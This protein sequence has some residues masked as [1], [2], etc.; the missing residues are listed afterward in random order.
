MDKRIFLY[1]GVSILSIAFCVIWTWLVTLRNRRKVAE[2]QARI[3][4][5]EQAMRDSL[6]FTTKDEFIHNLR[7]RVLHSR[8]ITPMVVLSQ[9]QF[10]TIDREELLLRIAEFDVDTIKNAVQDLVVLGME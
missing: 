4:A 5:R 8:F 9:L 3:D 2:I 10:G 6:K 1:V 7:R